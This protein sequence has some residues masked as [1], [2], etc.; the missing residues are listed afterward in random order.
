[1]PLQLSVAKSGSQCAHAKTLAGRVLAGHYGVANVLEKIEKAHM[2][3]SE[4]QVYLDLRDLFNFYRD[5]S[6]AI[7]QCASGFPTRLSNSSFSIS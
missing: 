7:E 1:M 4:D 6:M 3:N 2:L 5:S